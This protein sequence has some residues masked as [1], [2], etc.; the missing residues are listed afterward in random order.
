M[1]RTRVS[2]KQ[3]PQVGLRFGFLP[4]GTVH[5]PTV[6]DVVG[7]GLTSGD[8]AA[9]T[10]VNF[11]AGLVT[12]VTGNCGSPW[13]NH[14]SGSAGQKGGILTVTEFMAVDGPGS[15]SAIVI[16]VCSYRGHQL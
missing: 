14:S 11:V 9:T 5:Q 10:R 13:A 15:D 3:L 1:S 6:H 12:F 16:E 2:C 8:S 4:W 7:L